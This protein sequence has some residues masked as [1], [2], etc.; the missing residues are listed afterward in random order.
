V[1][2]EQMYAYSNDLVSSLE[3]KL[4]KHIGSETDR[5]LSIHT[6]FR[7]QLDKRLGD[8]HAFLSE[9]KDELDR[10]GERVRGNHG[11]VLG[12]QKGLASAVKRMRGDQVVQEEDMNRA[13][14]VVGMAIESVKELLSVMEGVSG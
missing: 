6:L 4:M 13:W 10:L 1:L 14:Q 9:V 8:E 7:E 11:E 5:L 12:L 3:R 2:K